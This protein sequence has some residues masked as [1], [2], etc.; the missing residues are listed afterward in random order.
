[1]KWGQVD[2]DRVS[3]ASKRSCQTGPNFPTIDADCFNLHPRTLLRYSV[4]MV[5]ITIMAHH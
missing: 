2:Q 3:A 1:M 5:E 4:R